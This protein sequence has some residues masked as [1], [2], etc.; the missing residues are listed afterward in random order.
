M[1]DFDFFIRRIKN[2]GIAGGIIAIF[3]GA[4]AAWLG[5]Q[6]AWT[7]G[8]SGIEQYDLDKIAPPGGTWNFLYTVPG[9]FGI[10]SGL[11]GVAA[12]MAA[13]NDI[14]RARRLFIAAGILSFPDVFVFIN[15][16][17][18]VLFFLAASDIKKGKEVLPEFGGKAPNGEY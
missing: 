7:P 9:V 18:V 3:A 4:F 15:I 14:K 10:L 5:A 2:S 1:K 16:A 12:G 6:I 8:F 13:Q 11:L 17:S